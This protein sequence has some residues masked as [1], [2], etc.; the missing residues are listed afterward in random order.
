MTWW[1]QFWFSPSHP[2]D[3]GI[4]RALFYAGV[5]VMYALE[6][7]SGWADV[8]IAFWMPMP[9]FELLGL[10]PMSAA[11]MQAAEVVWRVSLV[12][13]AVGLFSQVSMIVAA[14]LG[15][16]LLGLPHNFGHVFHFDATLVIIMFVLACSRAGDAFSI[17][18]SRRAT[19]PAPSGEYT[20]PIRMAWVA[21]ALVFFA[22]GLAKFRYGGLEWITS[23][24]MSVLL[25]R[26][27]YHTSD[28]DPISGLGLWIAQSPLLASVIAGMSAIIE[29][30]YPLALVSK[31][32]RV[33]FVPAAFMMLIGIRVLMGPT[34]GG[35]L[36]ANVFW[37]PW[38]AVL[39]RVRVFHKQHLSR[40][41]ALAAHP[42]ANAYRPSHIP[43]P[44]GSTRSPAS[45]RSPATAAIASAAHDLHPVPAAGPPGV[46]RDDSR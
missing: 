45:F 2:V 27:A 13:S 35:F 34:F 22:A 42:A 16:Y 17:D 20:W 36:V 29:F 32:A 24:N 43:S 33:F 19:K 39:A 38:S 14:V 11:A 23:E 6:D 4:A 46:Q 40:V 26:S 41:P 31:R 18:A 37:V 5:L 25:T 8:S 1:R 15:F 10:Q 7:F 28:A 21:I 3:L 9:V 12:L 44:N 30:A